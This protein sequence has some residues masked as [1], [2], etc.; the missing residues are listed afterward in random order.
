[1]RKIKVRMY[2][3]SEK[4]IKIPGTIYNGYYSDNPNFVYM[5]RTELLDK[6]GKP[7]YEGDVLKINVGQ[8][9]FESP[10][11]FDNGAFKIKFPPL[12]YHGGADKD[13]LEHWANNS[14]IIG[15]IYEK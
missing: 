7:I 13:I 10:V 14:E 8:D 6:T 9:D 4:K 2:D 3:F 1:M 5:E 15:N 11:I 12:F